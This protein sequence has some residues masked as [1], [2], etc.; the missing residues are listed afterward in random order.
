MVEIELDLQQ[1]HFKEQSVGWLMKAGAALDSYIESVS[2]KKKTIIDAIFHMPLIGLMIVWATLL[3]YSESRLLDMPLSLIRFFA[4]VPWILKT[5]SGLQTLFPAYRDM[6]VCIL[7]SWLSQA[8]YWILRSHIERQCFQDEFD[9]KLF[10]E[11]DDSNLPFL[12]AVVLISF[13]LKSCSKWAVLLNFFPIAVMYVPFFTE[14]RLLTEMYY[15][16][17]QSLNLNCV[18]NL[19]SYYNEVELVRLQKIISKITHQMQNETNEESVRI[20][21]ER[22][23]HYINLYNQHQS[24]IYSL[25]EQSFKHCINLSIVPFIIQ[26]LIVVLASDLEISGF[27][28]F[29]SC[30][31]KSPL[32]IFSAFGLASLISTIF[33]YIMHLVFRLVDIESNQLTFGLLHL[34]IAYGTLALFHDTDFVFI[35]TNSRQSIFPI[36]IVWSLSHCICVFLDTVEN[37]ILGIV[38]EGANGQMFK[39]FRI[40]TTA[41]I[42]AVGYIHISTAVANY[43]ILSVGT[44][45][46]FTKSSCVVVKSVCLFLSSILLFIS[47]L[48]SRVQD[49]AINMSEHMSFIQKCAL[50]VDTAIHLYTRMFCPIMTSWFLLRL[51]I[52]LFGFVVNLVLAHKDWKNYSFHNNVRAFIDGLPDVLQNN[53]CSICR[54]PLEVCKQLPCQHMYHGDCLKRWFR[55]RIAC[56]LCNAQFEIPQVQSF[57][58]NVISNITHRIF[59]R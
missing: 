41:V 48:P 57:I 7:A 33:R 28:L 25:M 51:P 53:D 12:T 52:N 3:P 29:Y 24:D 46:F 43:S 38:N 6:L 21:S 27:I 9:I 14:S 39:L 50:F 59:R 56:P 42:I 58:T 5:H 37:E 10:K 13:H 49:H 15:W 17:V 18:D 36:I 11:S 45:M 2:G 1:P 30:V 26:L 19:Y 23:H 8:V 40:L 31:I 47:H 16:S 35:D 55:T 32:N 20:A 4:C 44:Y 54:T 34:Q 22:L